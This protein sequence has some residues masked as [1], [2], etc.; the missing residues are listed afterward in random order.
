MIKSNNQEKIIELIIEKLFLLLNSP[1]TIIGEYII[2]M[3]DLY[4]RKYQKIN[5]KNINFFPLK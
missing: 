5:L 4:L 3:I 2:V 1:K